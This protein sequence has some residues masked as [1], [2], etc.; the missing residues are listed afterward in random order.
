MSQP[1]CSGHPPERSFGL[2]LLSV[3]RT[4]RARGRM[5]RDA[6]MRR[7]AVLR[8]GREEGSVW[9]KAWVS[10]CYRRWDYRHNLSFGVVFG[11]LNEWQKRA[12]QWQQREKLPEPNEAKAA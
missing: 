3:E 7:R 11:A 12:A 5:K 1:R 2:E 6:K 10:Q 4:G 9:A 8:L